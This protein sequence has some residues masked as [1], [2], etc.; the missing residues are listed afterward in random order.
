MEIFVS[1]LTFVIGASASAY[2][3]RRIYLQKIEIIEATRIGLQTLVNDKEKQVL[4]IS[5]QLQ[6][7]EGANKIFSQQ[8]SEEKIKAAGLEATGNHQ[9]QDAAILVQAKTE[10]T[11]KLKDIENLVMD[12]KQQNAVL[13][14]NN[15][16]LE[17]SIKSIDSS[18]ID[19]EKDSKKTIEE[20]RRKYE[21]V[22]KELTI[23]Q[24]QEPK[25]IIEYNRNIISLN[26]AMEKQKETEVRLLK[27][28]EQMAADVI[29]ALNETWARHE[30][31]VENKMMLICQQ[32]TIEYVDKEKFPL[33]GKPDNCVKICEEYIIF[34][35]KSPQGDELSNFPQYIKSQ[36]ESVK[37]YAKQVG[38]KKDIFLVVP[39][40]AIHV[41]RETVM[42]MGDYDVYVITTDA[43]RP[44][45]IQLKKV[46]YYEF[47]D[48]L[49]A[50][51]R[52]QIITVI[53]KM[54]HGM[55]RKIQLDH[56][57]ANEFISILMA[58]GNLPEDILKGA[59]EVE[60]KYKLNAPIEK[61][62][63]KIDNE[64]LAKAQATLTGKILGQEIHVGKEL[65][66]INAVPLYTQE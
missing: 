11:Q 28:K 14:A 49:S 58:A 33:T 63:K 36:A 16:S 2:L 55:K 26:H 51:D 8:L 62:V 41:I 1:I 6:E 44:I 64:E 9:K 40:N 25:R 34:D 29:K 3:V 21:E 32:E 5:S 27:E 24:E 17:K 46:K 7:A 31:D 50:E 45:L 4:A 52:G 59:V 37:K 12:L 39:T 22:S 15:Q 60:S 19:K 13:E 57:M 38:V 10:L 20:L 43:V 65:Q 61:R 48:K 18:Q 56:Y 53:G 47:A 66:T 42:K 23:V 30:Q 54:A 35:S